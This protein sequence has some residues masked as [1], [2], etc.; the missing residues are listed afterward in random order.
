MQTPPLLLSAI[1]LAGLS[2]FVES[3]TRNFS[4]FSPILAFAWIFLYHIPC[5]PF[6]Q[7][8]ANFAKTNSEL[9]RD[10][11]PL[12]FD[13]LFPLVTSTAV[14]NNGI[15]GTPTSPSVKWRHNSHASATNQAKEKG[16]LLSVQLISKVLAL[17]HQ[18]RDTAWDC[19]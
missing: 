16:M 8:P 17:S 2:A 6:L 11:S 14:T 9:C 15:L 5:F 19:S 13:P 4:S 18:C 1:A 7:S 10:L 3:Y 12:P